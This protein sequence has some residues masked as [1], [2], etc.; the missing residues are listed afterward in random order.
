MLIDLLVSSTAAKESLINSSS[1]LD[2]QVWVKV[3][4]GLS[5]ADCASLARLSDCQDKLTGVNLEICPPLSW[6]HSS[7]L[8]DKYLRQNLWL[9]TKWEMVLL[10]LSKSQPIAEKAGK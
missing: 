2:S 3:P 9:Q 8:H 10:A 4:S 5:L 6:L 1:F 7:V